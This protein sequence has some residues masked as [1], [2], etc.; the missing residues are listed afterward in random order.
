MGE[1]YLDNAAS[2]KPSKEVIEAIMPYLTDM[3]HN[4][5]SLYNPS[6]KIKNK[7][8]ESRKIIADFINA[9]EDEIYFTS[10]GSEGN[11][12][13]IQGFVNKCWT[14]GKQ[15]I[16]ITSTIEHKSILNCVNNLNADVYFVEVDNKGFVTWD[17]LE[18]ILMKALKY[19]KD[20]YIL[21][22]SI[23]VS[24]QLANNEVGTVQNAKMIS[25]IVHEYGGILHMDS[26]QAFGHI[27]INVKELGIDILTASGHKV[28][29]LKGVG[30]MYKK[31]E[32]DIKP[33]VYGTQENGMRGGTEN[34]I[35][36]IS[37]GEAVKHI[38]FG[39]N[40]E[41]FEE[42]IDKR[43]Y[44][45]NLLESK[46]GC[47]LNGCNE[48]RLPNNINV[49]FPNNITGESLLYMLDMEDIKVSTGSACNSH[50]IEP[51]YVLKA[52]GLTSEEAMKTVRFTL[53]ENITY[54]DIDKVVEEINKAIRLTELEGW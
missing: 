36:I 9:D 49:T 3:W 10:G 28:N 16:V 33:L 45:I 15:P 31:D 52:I 6:A 54:Q 18:N 51:S 47:K 11:S 25:N 22:Y 30:F 42:M 43:D 40:F 50:S 19:Q 44:F 35:G 41:K 2:T 32:I 14:S 12:W 1:I 23:L 24:I 20:N 53:S 13:A 38:D 26:V 34:V 46:F 48:Y 8:E 39:N 5:S 7:I 27:P 29:A 4:P 21:D 17:N 37:L